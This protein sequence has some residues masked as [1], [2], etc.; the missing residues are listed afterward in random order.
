[1]FK[2]QKSQRGAAWQKFASCFKPLVIF[3]LRLQKVYR[4][5]FSFILPPEITYLSPFFAAFLY[6]YS[7][8]SSEALRSVLL[9]D[10]F[11]CIGLPRGFCPPLALSSSL[12]DVWT[13][14]RGGPALAA[15]PSPLLWAPGGQRPSPTHC[16]SLTALPVAGTAPSELDERLLSLFSHIHSDTVLCRPSLPTSCWGGGSD[17]PFAL[18]LDRSPTLQDLHY[19]VNQ[20]FFT[21]WHF[22]ALQNHAWLKYLFE[23]Q[24]S[25]MDIS[26]EYEKKNPLLLL[27]IPQ[28]KRNYHSL[29]FDLYQG[30]I[31]TTIWKA[32]T[33]RP[34][35]GGC[36][37]HTVTCH[38]VL[39]S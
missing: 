12:T 13:Q 7:S 36:Q 10:S 24:D 26:I 22:I 16:C 29:D 33:L 20:C 25:S 28:W 15:A 6:D 4:V 32:F 37:I 14:V 8:P 17:L 1:M 18:S 2:K 38:S 35:P 34:T 30:K 9:S 23:A 27:H 21:E 39:N 5:L 31:S 19:S 11:R 3:R